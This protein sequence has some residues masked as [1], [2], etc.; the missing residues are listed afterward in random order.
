MSNEMLN[1]INNLEFGDSLTKLMSKNIC[2]YSSR[3]LESTT[4]LDKRTISNMKKGNNLTKLNVISACLGIHIPS[5]VSKK[6]LKLAE[7]TLDVD[8][9]GDKGTE[10]NTYDMM[11]HLK[12]A[13]DY[14]EI[15][16]ELNQQNLGH[17]IKNPK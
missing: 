3:L 9:P 13:T 5:K 16:D 11:L 17:L 14:D 6:L 10:N 15:C 12:W 8:L 4:G 2:N 7:I 1:A